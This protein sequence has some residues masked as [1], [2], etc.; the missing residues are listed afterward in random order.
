MALESVKMRRKGHC[1]LG[2]TEG[3]RKGGGKERQRERERMQR[4][5]GDYLVLYTIQV[6]SQN[7]LLSHRSLVLRQIDGVGRWLGEYR[8]NVYFLLFF[9]N[10]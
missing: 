2:M 3:E 1:Y 9:V 7:C 10:V 6:G 5:E 8:E 4:G